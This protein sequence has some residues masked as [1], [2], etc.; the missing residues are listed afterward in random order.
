MA[1]KRKTKSVK[2]A[3]GPQPAESAP[4]VSV[5]AAESVSV[6]EASIP[7]EEES[8]SEPEEHH[9][10]KQYDE[11]DSFST[12][13]V[14]TWAVG[15]LLF[16]GILGG[17]FYMT[18]QQGIKAGENNIKSQVALTPTPP[19][20][21]PT[22]K[23]VKADAYE[24]KIL[25]GSGIGGEAAK[26]QALLEKNNYKI[27]S[28]GNSEDSVEKTIIAAKSDV[29]KGWI[30]DLRV[31]LGDTY[32]VSEPETLDESEDVDVIITVGSSKASP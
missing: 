12:K 10:S 1:A 20:A 22:P 18:Y 23:A 7:V 25:N 19:E 3:L 15:I 13:K 30:N 27:E 29:S 6:V 4:Q 21:T 11:D 31:V 32:E 17:A 28:I 26:V 14:I 16:V 2:K 8:K 24:I 5:V 9:I